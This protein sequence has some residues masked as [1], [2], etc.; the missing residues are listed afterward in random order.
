MFICKLE[1]LLL[2]AI[3]A[4]FPGKYG[5]LGASVHELSTMGT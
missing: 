5:P 3:T 4:L 2:V 1:K